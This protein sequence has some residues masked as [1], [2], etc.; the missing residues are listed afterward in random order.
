[1]RIP[2]PQRETEVAPEGPPIGRHSLLREMN[3]AA[4][5]EAVSELR[6]FTM[7]ALARKT[8]LSQGTL[9]TIVR[10]LVEEGF[11][12]PLQDG[13]S[14][15][16]RPPRR[17]AWNPRA[18]LVVGVDLDARG[19]LA[20]GVADLDG[21]VVGEVG[22]W[23][24]RGLEVEPAEVLEAIEEA[25][26][27]AGVDRERLV[28][29]GCAARGVLD[30][31]TG[32]VLWGSTLPW[33]NVP[34]REMLE[35]QFAVPAWV[36]DYSRV[37]ALAEHALLGSRAARDLIYVHV[38]RGV[39]AGIV[40]AGQIYPRAGGHAGEF[41]HT[42]VAMDGEPCACGRHG[43]LE[44]LASWS[45]VRRRIAA[46]LE[47]GAASRLG[48]AEQFAPDLR[49]EDITT[50]AEAGDVVAREAIH[51]A[52][53]CAARG[54]A[55]LVN[56]LNPERVV[57]GGSLVEACP[58]ALTLMKQIV[59][60]ESMPTAAARAELVAPALSHNAGLRAAAMLALRGWSES[61]EW[62]RSKA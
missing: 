60:A 46:A 29:I 58:Q 11:V 41:G 53:A 34:L 52:V 31:A 43:C 10:H 27:G 22:S 6:R 18:R 44:T 2:Y 61:S 50:A 39:S 35:A 32:T 8:A 40:I 14:E 23:P 38:G 24:T 3:T 48:T 36:E 7:L 42:V 13:P 21:N 45:A 55:N 12:R 26:C 9:T 47:G 57:V 4:V 1:M 33:R 17:Y 54:I 37:M 30:P 5:L 62:L 25:L 49:L 16:G 28:G 51:A 59:T 15:G 20:A 56:L 19:G